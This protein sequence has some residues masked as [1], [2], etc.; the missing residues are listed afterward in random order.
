MVGSGMGGKVSEAAQTVGE[1]VVK[2]VV[3]EFG[4]AVE[5]GA[6]TIAG[7]QSSQDPQI[8]QRKQEEEQKR[9][10]WALRV[11]D[12]NKKLDA[13]LQ[14]V[15]Q[16][17]QQAE[18]QRLQ[19]MQQQTQKEQAQIIEKQQKKAQLTAVER[20]ARKTELKGGVGG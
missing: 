5:E 2:P 10:D 8:Q 6:Q 19:S 12:W 15:R 9:K 20:E 18:Q 1:A 11:I 14:K 3:D 7:S 17:K 16:Q 13:D 4:K